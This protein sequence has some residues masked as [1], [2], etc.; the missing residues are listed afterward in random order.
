MELQLAIDGLDIKQTEEL[1]DKVNNYVDIV[2]IGT[3]MIIRFGLEPVKIISEKYKNIKVL[4]D[5]KIMDGGYWEAK[6]AFEAG[7]S[8][9]TVCSAAPDETIKGAIKAAN[10]YGKEILVDLINV[11]EEDFEERV[12]FLEIIGAHYICVHISADSR[13]DG[14]KNNTQAVK[15]VKTLAKLV[16]TSKVACA[17]GINMEVIHDII[18]AKPDDIIVGGSITMAPDPVA[19]C[20][21]MYETIKG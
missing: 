13:A 11:K 18:S 3:P 20:K 1:V 12:K 2:E 14:V 16:S 7:A 21:Q 19:A 5:T 8:I 4:A 9:V 17:G 15:E 10:E 6:F